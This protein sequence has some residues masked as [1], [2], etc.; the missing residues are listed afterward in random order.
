MKVAD[1]SFRFVK[2]RETQTHT[3][4]PLLKSQQTIS[5]L[6]R[7]IAF[8]FM[9]TR[10]LVYVYNI[11]F[12]Y[13]IYGLKRSVLVALEETLHIHRHGFNHESRKRELQLH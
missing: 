9:Y 1:G 4:E 3:H 10:A 12:K 6:E 13:Q 2:Y 5:L 8:N 7:T 11:R